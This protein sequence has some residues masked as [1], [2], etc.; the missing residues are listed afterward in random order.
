MGVTCG[1]GGSGPRH[2]RLAAHAFFG[3]PAESAAKVFIST[4]QYRRV[5]S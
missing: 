3:A 1:G 2:L 4:A 5:Q